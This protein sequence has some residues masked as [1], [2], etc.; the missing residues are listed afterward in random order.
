MTF[1]VS[2]WTSCSKRRS[3]TSFSSSIIRIL[4]FFSYLISLF[5]GFSVLNGWFF[6]KL[7][8]D[9]FLLTNLSQSWICLSLWPLVYWI[10]LISVPIFFLFYGSKKTSSDEIL[11]WA[12]DYL[13][14][15]MIFLDFWFFSAS[16][17]E[18]SAK[19]GPK[20][21]RIERADEEAPHYAALILL[22]RAKRCLLFERPSRSFV[23]DFWETGV[24]ISLLFD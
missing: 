16:R 11:A 3:K 19:L 23:G 24:P 5:L 17:R 15:V 21:C 20:S 14:T 1:W 10:W 13:P 4:C 7:V 6:R 12:H 22:R 18:L 8:S 9:Y 2:D